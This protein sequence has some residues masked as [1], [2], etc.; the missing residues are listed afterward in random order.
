MRIEMAKGKRKEDV[1]LPNDT[2][3]SDLHFDPN[4]K[5]KPGREPLRGKGERYPYA[6]EMTDKGLT[7]RG[8]TRA[9]KRASRSSSSR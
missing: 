3:T 8:K 4:I 5:R 6:F 7:Y 2:G 1:S 9:T